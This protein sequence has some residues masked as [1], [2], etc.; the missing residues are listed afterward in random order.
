MP[1]KMS[2]TNVQPKTDL[3]FSEKG[4]ISFYMSSTE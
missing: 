4:I 2:N 3:Q 1:V